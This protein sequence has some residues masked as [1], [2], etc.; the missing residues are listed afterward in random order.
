MLVSIAV[1]EK[2]KQDR[3]NRALYIRSLILIKFELKF[4][5]KKIFTLTLES[6]EQAAQVVSEIS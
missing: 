3:Q 6:Q 4:V 2:I 5:N 1:L